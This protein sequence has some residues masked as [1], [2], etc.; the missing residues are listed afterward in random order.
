MP[1]RYNIP[2]QYKGDSFDIITFNF[3][4]DSSEVGNEIDLTGA[5]PKM[6]IRKDISGTLIKT[7]TIGDGLEWVDQ[8]A[9]VFRTTSFIIDFDDD[10]YDYD[11]QITYSSGRVKTYLRG[12]ITVVQDVTT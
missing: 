1:K 8:D 12:Q 3:F 4:T 11:L 6:Q 2:N 10:I 5:T 7:L 9:G